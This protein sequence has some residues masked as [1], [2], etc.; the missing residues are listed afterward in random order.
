MKIS[1][2]YIEQLSYTDFVALINQTNVPP[3][4]YST[5][6]KWKSN[7]SLNENSLIL[8][9]ACTTGF[10]VLNLCK[11][12]N[13]KGVGI[14]ICNSSI[15]QAKINSET[16]DID[17]KTEFIAMDATQYC[18]DK[19]FSHIVV[20]A[21]L[22]FFPN[23]QEMIDKITNLLEDGGYLLASP[24]YVTKDIPQ[25]LMLEA[26]KVFGIL[27]TNIGYKEVMSL[28]SGF[29]VH[30]EDRLDLIEETE[31]ELAHYCESTINRA[32]E[33]INL[34]DDDAYQSLYDRLYKIKKMSNKLRPYQGY[35]VLVLRYQEKTYPNRF[36]ELF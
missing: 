30:Y 16:L 31:K 5:L 21:G 22:G 19:K 35:S 3:G 28:Y 1:K 34:E 10:S 25:S 24:F 8:E 18:N 4:S 32:I 27:P 15:K 7:S 33:S 2:Q 23:P 26:E 13:C 14:D 6:T 9:A 29:E 36:V 17:D 12:T 20:G 11:E